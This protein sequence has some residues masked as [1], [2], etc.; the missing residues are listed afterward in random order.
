M[1]AGNKAI[2]VAI[3]VLLVAGCGGI[4][5]KLDEQKRQANE[6]LHQTTIS[7]AEW[8]VKKAHEHCDK[9][10]TAQQNVKASREKLKE[11]N[12][13][14]GPESEGI[15]REGCL[16]LWTTG[17]GYRQLCS[18]F[19]RVREKSYTDRDPESRYYMKDAIERADAILELGGLRPCK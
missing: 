5:Q 6:D 11:L 8:M 17:P 9:L 15:T 10:E 12:V 18:L 13:D 2:V 7:T 19:A 4:K 3:S 14:L 1:H 16:I